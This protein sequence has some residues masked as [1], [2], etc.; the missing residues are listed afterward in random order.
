MTPNIPDHYLWLGLGVFTFVAIHQVSR[1]LNNILELTTI[2]NSPAPPP[3]TLPPNTTHQ[4]DSIHPS[5]LLLLATSH[6]TELRASATRIL[7]TRFYANKS[8]RKALLRDLKSADEDTRRKAQLA[9]NMLCELGIWK[10]GQVARMGRRV[11]RW[12]VIGNVERDGQERGIGAEE[13][14]RD[15]RRRRREAVV[16]H[17]GEGVVGSEDVYMRGGETGSMDDGGLES[18]V[19]S[20]AVGG[21][22][23]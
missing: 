13:R 10:E 1:G 4:E 17:D 22:D 6:N 11:G 20:L 18:F 9:M 8:A 21:L 15:V 3:S 2:H 14:E 5:S 19:A 7:C 12:R 16:I 23:T